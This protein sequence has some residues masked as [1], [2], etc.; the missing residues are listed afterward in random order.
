MAKILSIVVTKKHVAE[1]AE[2]AVS[3]RKRFRMLP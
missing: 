2:M 1:I 3:K